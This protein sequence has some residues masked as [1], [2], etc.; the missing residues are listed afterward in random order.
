MK[1]YYDLDPD[2]IED[3]ELDHALDNIVK[4]SPANERKAMSRFVEAHKAMRSHLAIL[5]SEKTKF[6]LM[7]SLRSIEK[8]IDMEGGMII[9]T[10]DSKIELKDF[11]P[12]I[13]ETIVRLLNEKM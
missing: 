7:W 3:K 11:S 2:L 13:S 9:I 8:E 1:V 10:K 5:H 4:T 6:Q 12:E